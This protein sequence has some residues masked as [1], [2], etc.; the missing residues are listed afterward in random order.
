MKGIRSSGVAGA[1]ALALVGTAPAAP[2]AGTLRVEEGAVA[3]QGGR[4]LRTRRVADAAPVRLWDEIKTA[5][6]AAAALEVFDQGTVALD[7]ASNY[8][9]ERDG[10]YRDAG[11]GPLRIYQFAMRL[12]GKTRWREGAERRGLSG[13]LY[14]TGEVSVLRAGRTAWEPVAGPAEV[15]PNDRVRT[16]PEAG[17]VLVMG[18]AAR[19]LLEADTDARLQRD[20]VVLERGG[21][22]THWR[23]RGEQ[24]EI[25]TPLAIV[26]VRG[27]VFRVRHGSGETDEVRVLEGKV[28]VDARRAR[29]GRVLGPGLLARVASAGP[30][31]A[32]RFAPEAEALAIARR[33]TEGLEQAARIQVGDAGGRAPATGKATRPEGDASIREL[34]PEAF[35]RVLKDGA[36]EDVEADRLTATSSKD[37]SAGTNLD[38]LVPGGTSSVPSTSRDA[39]APSTRGEVAPDGST[40]VDK[41]TPGGVESQILGLVAPDGATSEARGDS[42]ERTLGLVA[43]EGT[44]TSFGTPDGGAEPRS[45]GLVAPDGS[46]ALAPRDPG[47]PRSRPAARGGWPSRPAGRAGAGGSAW[48]GWSG[49]APRRSLGLLSPDRSSQILDRGARWTPP[50]A[51]AASLPAPATHE[52][53]VPGLGSSRVPRDAWAPGR[54]TSPVAPPPRARPAP[55]VRKVLPR[56]DRGVVRTPG[57]RG[58]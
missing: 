45:L 12:G 46:G 53:V 31:K 51:A 4:P 43:P 14:P 2:T 42:E 33:V 41:T 5:Q 16:G 35:R 36:G 13:T 34:D 20:A 29:A 37:A 23:R 19:L 10:V 39:L 32:A 11:T 6:D 56:P 48:P 47:P 54:E 21:V 9:I 15:G 1:L 22:L 25:H 7:G 18:E 52:R 27:T 44:S 28:R 17:A 30:P 50:A 24:F 8:S 26:G 40:S 55:R 58:L 49:A 38:R 3:I 57:L